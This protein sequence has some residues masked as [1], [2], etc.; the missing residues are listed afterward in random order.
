MITSTASTHPRS[1]SITAFRLCTLGVVLTA[2][3]G[4]GSSGDTGSGGAPDGGGTQGQVEDVR[5]DRYC[6][7]LIGKLSGTK[8]HIEV[9]NTYGLDECPDDQ[10]KAIDADAVKAAEEADAVILNGPRYWMVD[11]FVSS[12]LLDAT[13]K[14]IGGIDMRLAGTLDLP[15]SEVKAGEVPYAPRDVTR[16]TTWVFEAKKSVFELV[17]PGGRVFDMQS[18]SV[19]KTQQTQH[20]LA[21]LGNKLTLP[22]GWQFRTRELAEDLHVTAVNGVATVV[23]DDLGNT[24][25][26]SQQ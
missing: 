1:A 3:L 22:E 11:E 17:D 15:L 14:T 9:Y 4:C 5:G 2:A 21:S 20:S 25:Q 8:V 6:E 24:Y 13:P 10:W 7:I 23:Q 12:A 18:Y 19:Q 26:L 16:N